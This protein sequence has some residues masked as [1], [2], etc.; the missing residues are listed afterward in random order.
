M[1]RKRAATLGTE[2]LQREVDFELF[3]RGEIAAS[4]KTTTSTGKQQ[5]NVEM[6]Q[7]LGTSSARDSARFVVTTLAQE[8][9]DLP[10]SDSRIDDEPIPGVRVSKT[11][12]HHR[13]TSSRVLDEIPINPLFELSRE[14]SVPER[15][16]SCP[17][18]GTRSWFEENGIDI[19]PSYIGRDLHK[20]SIDRQ[21]EPER[22]RA[23]PVDRNKEIYHS[24]EG[25]HNRLM[26]R[27]VRNGKIQG[28]LKNGYIE[29]SGKKA[30]LTKAGEKNNC[31]S[32]VNLEKKVPKM[33]GPLAPSL[34][35]C[36]CP[37]LQFCC[38][39]RHRPRVQSHGMRF[40]R[41]R[42]QSPHHTVGEETVRDGGST[43]VAWDI[44][45]EG[46]IRE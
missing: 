28:A 24:E 18:L 11:K 37:R 35:P 14:D 4:K 6:P 7:A 45:S 19:G 21:E 29:R 41:C 36:H 20:G 40:M 44:V 33:D 30:V 3:N 27:N 34:V 26:G 22:I 13:R 10:V 39:D 16:S 2:V 9:Y 31:V 1:Q 5:I 46:G 8:S 15:G 43:G 17:R 42:R 25:R 23:D 12:P 38:G 32:L